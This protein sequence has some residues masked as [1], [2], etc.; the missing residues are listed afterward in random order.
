MRSLGPL[1]CEILN[2]DFYKKAKLKNLLMTISLI[3][4]FI[5]LKKS[6]PQYFFHYLTKNKS[7]C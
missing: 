5:S 7:R 3:S 6:T 1:H 2:A 4:H